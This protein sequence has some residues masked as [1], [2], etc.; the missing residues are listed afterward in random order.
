[1]LGPVADYSGTPLRTKV[2]IGEGATVALIDAPGDL[3]SNLP[4]SVAVKRRASGRAEVVVAF[5]TS[6]AKLNRRIDHLG[7]ITSD[8]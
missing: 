5:F 4:A 1:M 8:R 3:R 7:S 6:S 2:G